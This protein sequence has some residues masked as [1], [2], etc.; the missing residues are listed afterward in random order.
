MGVP[1]FFRYISERYPCL[2]QLVLECEVSSLEK[3]SR[4]SSYRCIHVALC[5]SVPT[6]HDVMLCFQIP[7]FDNLYL[8]MNGIIHNCSHPG[9]YDPH[10]RISEEKIFKDIFHYIEVIHNTRLH[11]TN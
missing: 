2:S 6:P 3:K 5:Y 7:E 9:E 10:F 1:K 4:F 11:E 8:D